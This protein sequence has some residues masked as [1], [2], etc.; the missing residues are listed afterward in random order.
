MR[1]V[2]KGCPLTCFC[3]ALAFDPFLNWFEL[4]IIQH[5]KGIVRACADDVGS[6]VKS[7]EHLP[8]MASIFK[9]ARPLAGFTLKFRKCYLVPVRPWS[10]DLEATI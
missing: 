8:T 4:A 2:I 1:G 5:N 7:L 10:D 9:F 6:A 3:F